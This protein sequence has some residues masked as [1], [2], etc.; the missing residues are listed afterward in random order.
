[1][2]EDFWT[3][4]PTHKLLISGNHKPVVR[5][6]DDGIWRRWRLL[7]FE[8]TIAEADRDPE[9]TEK[10]I[11]EMP[12]ILAWA[13]QGCIAWQRD[14]LKPSSKVLVATADYRSESDRLGP[15]VDECCT[16]DSQA[17]IPRAVLYRSYQQWSDVQGE[18]RALSEKDFAEYVRGRGV[19]EC[20]TRS[21]GKKCRGWRGIE[22]ATGGNTKTID[23]SLNSS[24]QA[25][26][27]ANP[28]NKREVLSGVAGT[29][30]QEEG[31]V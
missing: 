14:G 23:F 6:Q 7:P 19:T 22:L 16:L 18:R 11:A 31:A 30:D 1:M 8:R 29:P 4:R 17:S 25:S 10:L 20:W 26:R 5:G 21:D 3:F 9:L 27:E 24:V 15:F 12:G 28:E 2:R 13:V